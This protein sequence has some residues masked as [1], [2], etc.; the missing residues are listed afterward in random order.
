MKK[1]CF[2]CFCLVCSD[3]P[4]QDLPPQTEQQLETAA[5][6][7]GDELQAEDQYLEEIDYFKKHPVNL[8]LASREE[9]QAL[10]VLTDLQIA[11]LLAYRKLFGK[12]ID[13]SELQAVPGWD[14]ITIRKIL[15]YITIADPIPFRE[16]FA[17][18]LRGE[19]RL[20]LGIS[21]VLEKAKGYQ[22][23]SGSHYLGDRN[24][25]LLRYQYKYKDL[26]SFGMVGDKDPGE[27]FFKGTQS[28]GFDFYSAHFFLRNLG[29]IK[30]LAVGD[31][32]VNLGQGLIQ[33]QTQGFGKSAEVMSIKRQSSV[34]LPYRSSGE[35]RFSRGIGITL[36]K[37][38][39][40]ATLFASYR[41]ISGNI[42]RGDSLKQF[43]SILTSGY[44]RTPSEIADRYR[45]PETCF[46]GNISF[47]RNDFKIGLNAVTHRFG[48]PMQQTEETY[49]L[50]A[51]QGEKGYNWGMDY[52]Y[53]IKN[54]HLFGEAAV[55]QHLHHAVIS[56]ILMSVDPKIDLSFLFRDIQKEYQT[57]FGNAFTENTRPGNE[58]GIYAGLSV[59][60]NRVW[61]INAYSDFFSFPWLRYRANA[62]GRGYEYGIQMDYQPDK[63]F[64]FYLRYRN[65]NKPL[66]GA[67]EMVIPYP[68]DQVKQSLRAHYS[69]QVTAFFSIKSRLEILWFREGQGETSQ[70]FLGFVETGCRPLQKITANFRLQYFETDGYDARIYAYE[71][72]GV[73]S[74][75]IPAFY[76]RGFRWYLNLRLDQG[77]HCS[78][79]FRYAQT[80]FHGVHEIG[81][82]LEAITGNKKTELNLQLLMSF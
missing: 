21:R 32:T 61:Q 74:V 12:L 66:D 15:P 8:N 3:C 38:N 44:Y 78:I 2:I 75:S 79:W 18:R 49:K 1:I 39:L 53:T 56:G 22:T 72:E 29:C 33:W 67:E 28:G 80:V 36:K 13:I 52:S 58:R 63:R 9:M 60:P 24:Q 45:V 71:P 43:T 64:E 42:S 4:A 14:L 62:P 30:A 17:S 5:N 47:E 23:T 20:I 6:A 82:S 16:D 46:G 73:Y 70:G 10:H 11:H 50:Y 19:H 40:A 81:S 37:K 76:G 35:Y 54:I 27:Q 51:M 59:K 48:L 26:L 41:K 55:D 7:S 69:Q 57:L 34:L 65:K 77:P 25:V 68:A 31:F